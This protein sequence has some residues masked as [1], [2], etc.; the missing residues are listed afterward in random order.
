MDFGM[1]QTKAI[2]INTNAGFNYFAQR[3]D[4]VTAEIGNL[5]TAVATLNDKADNQHRLSTGQAIIVPG[6]SS[7]QVQEANRQAVVIVQGQTRAIT[8]FRKGEAD[9]TPAMAAKLEELRDSTVSST[10]QT[11]SSSD[12]APQPKAKAKGKAKAKAKAGASPSSFLA[13]PQPAQLI[14]SDTPL[15]EV[16]HG[17]CWSSLSPKGHEDLESLNPKLLPQHLLDAL[18]VFAQQHLNDVQA[19]T[20]ARTKKPLESRPKLVWGIKDSAHQGYALY[21]W[22]QAL[23]DYGRIGDPPKLISDLMTFMSGECGEAFNHCI[24]QVYSSGAAGIGPHQDKAFTAESTGAVENSTTKICDLSIGAVRTFM[25]LTADCPESEDAEALKDFCVASLAM[26]H[27]SY[28]TISGK[29]N[30]F[31]KHAVP[32]DPT[33]S[34]VRCSLVFRKVSKWFVHP[35]NDEIRSS[36]DR[37][38]KALKNTKGEI[39]KM[40]RQTMPEIDQE[41]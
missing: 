4:K 40:I 3:F 16:I 21:I 31:F 9:D 39:V 1:K 7:R 28:M 18:T 25:V 23:Q 36:K 19:H 11:A 38:W 8:A 32:L 27:G 29:C 34:A 33:V 30:S 37:E 15:A 35:V 10:A 14:P 17:P 2:N 5:S 41:S 22:K 20:M 26:T 24:F 13:E 12:Q 6:L